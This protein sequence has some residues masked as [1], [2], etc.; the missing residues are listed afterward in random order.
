[1][2]RPWRGPAYWLVP[3]G[4]LS[5]LSYRAQG[6]QPEDG[7]TQSGQILPHKSLIKNMLAGLPTAQSY[8]GIVS[9]ESLSSQVTLACVVDT[10]LARAERFGTA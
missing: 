9:V 4:L 5:L 6:H 8:G 2:Q 1:M 10:E 7:P 3:H